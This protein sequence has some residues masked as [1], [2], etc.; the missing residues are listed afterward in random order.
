MSTKQIL[1][2][3]RKLIEQGWCG[4][5]AVVVNICDTRACDAG[6]KPLRTRNVVNA[7]RGLLLIVGRLMGEKVK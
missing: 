7:L 6:T 1:V 3:T 2:E 4:N 5:G